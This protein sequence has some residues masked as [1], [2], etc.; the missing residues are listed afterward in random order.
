MSK[1][2]EFV[3]SML[4]IVGLLLA[5]VPAMALEPSVSEAIHDPAAP[6]GI[7]WYEVV[8]PYAM[9][10]RDK[11]DL[12]EHGGWTGEYVFGMTKGLMRSTLTPAL[13]PVFL[14]FT[15][16]LD[17]VFLPFAAIGGFFR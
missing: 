7:T 14:I 3:T 10:A 12:E 11:V 6:D 17:I 8:P 1:S 15:V 16:P 4:V 5:S 9:N 2:I 13:K